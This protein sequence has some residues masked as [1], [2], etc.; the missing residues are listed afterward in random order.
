MREM[1]G[2]QLPSLLPFQPSSP[3]LAGRGAGS[4]ARPESQTRAE[5][6]LCTEMAR[7]P[8]GL[9]SRLPR[10]PLRA[11]YPPH[12]QWGLS[13][14]CAPSPSPGAAGW[15]LLQTCVPPAATQDTRGRSSARVPCCSPRSHTMSWRV[16]SRGS[17]PRVLFKVGR[18]VRLG[19]SNMLSISTRKL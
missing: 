3:E 12:A 14:V 5:A 10:A 13:S 11:L 1:F 18:P 2:E 4:G 7:A 17:L 16:W 6:K 8:K 19:E 15:A 9:G